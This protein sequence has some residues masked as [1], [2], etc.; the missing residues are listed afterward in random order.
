MRV[1]HGIGSRLRSNLVV[2]LPPVIMN[3]DNEF[4]AMEQRLAATLVNL[5]QSTVGYSER[6]Q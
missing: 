2:Q 6:P 1:Q 5:L 3:L 4:L